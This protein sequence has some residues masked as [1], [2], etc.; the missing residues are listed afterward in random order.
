MSS[1]ARDV[2][3][4]DRV[5]VLRGFRIVGDESTP[6]ELILTIETTEQTP[7]LCP[8]C[9]TK[10]RALGRYPASKF[11][12]R[13]SWGRRLV[14]VQCVAAHVLSQRGLG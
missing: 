3:T 14:R 4:S 5:L 8:R 9:D 11:R 13:Q 12:Y 7:P 1:N 10:T 2:S 6:N